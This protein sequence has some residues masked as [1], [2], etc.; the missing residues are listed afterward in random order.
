[1]D[2]SHSSTAYKSQEADELHTN[3]CCF[4]FV[5]C[6]MEILA[7]R[8]QNFTLRY[9]DII[10]LAMPRADTLIVYV[11]IEFHCQY[12]SLKLTS[13][14]LPNPLSNGNCLFDG[15][16]NTNKHRVF[17]IINH[18]LFTMPF[19]TAFSVLVISLHLGLI[20]TFVPH[21]LLGCFT[22]P[23]NNNK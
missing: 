6:V 7:V 14:G 1:M 15:Y 22:T 20:E 8:S 23:K 11:H 21:K 4:L 10:I 17:S 18:F 5:G 16:N 19:F 13:L 3:Q 2:G 9:T 12:S